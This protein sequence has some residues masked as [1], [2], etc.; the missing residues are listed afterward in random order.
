MLTAN[1]VIGRDFVLL[2]YQAVV[3]RANSGMDFCEESTIPNLVHGGNSLAQIDVQTSF[4]MGCRSFCQAFPQSTQIGIAPSTIVWS[5]FA[6]LSGAIWRTQIVG[7]AS[8]SIDCFG[9]YLA[10]FCLNSSR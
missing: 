5:K 4:E 6:G 8:G 1:M 2:L 7:Q 3:G 10:W 9:C